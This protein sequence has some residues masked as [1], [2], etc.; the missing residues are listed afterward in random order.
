MEIPKMTRQT[1]VLDIQDLAIPFE[2]INGS[3]RALDGVNL[4]IK[5]GTTLGLVGESESG[6]SVMALSI[7]RLL[8]EKVSKITNGHLNYYPKDAD[9]AIG[10]SRLK[11]DVRHGLALSLFVSQLQA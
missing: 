9:T 1:P 4:S 3:I 5:S 7:L 8:P 2:T 6:K 10:L 11:A